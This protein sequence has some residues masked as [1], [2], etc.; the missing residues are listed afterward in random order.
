[1]AC[2]IDYDVCSI[3]GNK[4]TTPRGPCDQP[5]EVPSGGYCK[6]AKSMLGALLDDGRRVYV[7]NPHPIFFDIS[8]VGKPAEVIARTMRF[9]AAGQSGL[10]VPYDRSGVG[11][12]ELCGL[13]APLYVRASLPPCRALK[14]AVARKLAEMEKQIPLTLQRFRRLLPGIPVRSQQTDAALAEMTGKQASDNLLAACRRRRII[15]DFDAFCA[16]TKQANTQPS[17]AG[18]FARLGDAE[19]LSDVAGDGTYDDCKMSL[20]AVAVTEKLA[21]QLSLSPVHVR[22]RLISNPEP[23]HVPGAVVPQTE[24]QERQAR[25][26]AAYL[27]SELASQE[28]E[29]DREL[30]AALTV[31]RHHVKCN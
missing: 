30:E 18:L 1:M 17:L 21:S 19:L 20:Q 26:Y 12:A 23:R 7:D 9:K 31:L 22:D 4:A 2:K 27:L 14:L 24:A 8:Q 13:E 10:L 15:L 6:H 29:S 11:L 5:P 16:V 3:C 25:K 28:E